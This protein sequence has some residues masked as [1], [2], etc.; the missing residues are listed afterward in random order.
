[1]NGLTADP[2]LRHW[3]P[4]LEGSDFPTQRGSP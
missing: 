2:A 1:M 3:V 4:A